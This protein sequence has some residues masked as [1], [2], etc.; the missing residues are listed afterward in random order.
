MKKMLYIIE[1]GEPKIPGEVSENGVGN[2]EFNKREMVYELGGN[3]KCDFA[4]EI[5]H[6]YEL[7]P[8]LTSVLM[9]NEYDIDP[10]STRKYTFVERYPKLIEAIRQGKIKINQYF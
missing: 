7:S 2:K 10:R 4:Y 3:Q 1:V 6:F 9:K 5:K 8:S